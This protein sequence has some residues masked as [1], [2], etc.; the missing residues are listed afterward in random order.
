MPDQH[1]LVQILLLDELL[2]VLRHVV[3]VMLMGMEGVAMVPEILK[4][5]A[6]DKF[7]AF[8]ELHCT[9]RTLKRTRVKI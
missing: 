8:E 4:R 6:S 1:T 7:L 5:S 2:H 3:V 9:H